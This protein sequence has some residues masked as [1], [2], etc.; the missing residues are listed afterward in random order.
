MSDV[1]IAATTP[2]GCG[3]CVHGCIT[4][5]PAPVSIEEGTN[6]LFRPTLSISSTGLSFQ[7]QVSVGGGAWTN[8]SNGGV[9]SGATNRTLNL[10]A[11][12]LS[13]DGNA[14]RVNI[15][16][17]N[18]TQTSDG[19]GLTV[20]PCVE[21]EPTDSNTNSPTTRSVSFTG[22]PGGGR[23]DIIVA[24]SVS[25][26]SGPWS[27]GTGGSHSGLTNGR[28]SVLSATGFTANYTGPGTTPTIT[29]ISVYGLFISMPGGS[30]G[31]NNVGQCATFSGSLNDGVTVFFSG[32]STALIG[33][34]GT[35]YCPCLN[36]GGHVCPWS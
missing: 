12:P 2:T 19:A 30:A 5:Q 34:A 36:T 14:Y 33:H 22:S 18:C 8:V 1:V 17:A 26:V 25:C 10:T 28:D 23:A 4:V 9:Y 13:Y 31:P 24:G 29:A 21:V 11:V 6:T 35:L 15:S 20:T 7:W 32:G 3:C 16:G 27:F